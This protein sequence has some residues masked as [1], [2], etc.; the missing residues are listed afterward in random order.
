MNSSVVEVLKESLIEKNV[1]FLLG[2]GASA[3]YFSSLGNFEEILSN[4]N[5]DYRG[6]N[7][8][9]ALF[10]YQSIRDN[11]Y[12]H[13]FMFDKCC[14]NDK[15][16]LMLSIIDEYSRF[17]HNGIEFLKVRN[18]R[19][20]PK[21]LNVITTNYDLFIE[22]SIDR[23][24]EMNPRIFFNDGTNGYGKR[25]ISTDNFNKTLLYSGVF[26][27]YSNEM[28]AVNLIKCHGSINWK[29]YAKNNNR[30]KI[31]V[32]I[33]E[34]LISPINNDLEI[35]IQEINQYFKEFP[36]IMNTDSLENLIENMNNI[37]L[38]NEGLINELNFI[39]EHAG[40]SL[41]KLIEKVEALQ[42]VLP[43]KDKFQTTLIKEHYFS[44]LRLLSYELEKKQSLLV[45]FGFSF[46]DEHIL[47]IVQRSLN[48]PALL[49]IIFCFTDNEKSNIISQFNFSIGNVP[50]NIK[51]IEPKDFLVKEMDEEDY[52]EE[53]ENQDDKNF[54]VITNEG[55]VSIYSNV[56]SKLENEA[57]NS[58]IPVLNFSSFNSILEMDIA[59][60]Y[61]PIVG[62]ETEK[63]KETG[64][65][66]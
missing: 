9:K 29:E 37:E 36:F 8:V 42:I 1:T 61:I 12:L 39:G 49:V 33:E 53:E 34:N 40:E 22:S 7:L 38:V 50:I 43:T 47:E 66:E 31:Q 41:S 30:S 54:T 65:T 48:N 5:I 21:R 64:D 35:V 16:D 23:L 56:V 46:Q 2:A 17:I 15:K 28:P 14:C 26:D 25:V 19:I 60:K 59:N 3:P 32:A 57:G 11:I 18:S 52:M 4:E 44:M 45:V 63:E 20:S 13:H 27:N 24:L 10:Y 58:V 62:K 51:F 55:R 6:K